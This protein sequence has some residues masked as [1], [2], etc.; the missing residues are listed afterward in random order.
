MTT[1]RRNQSIMLRLCAVLLVLAACTDDGEPVSETNTQEEIDEEVTEPALVDGRLRLL[2]TSW[3]FDESFSVGS[4]FEPSTLVFFGQ[5]N[6]LRFEVEALCG[7]GVGTITETANGLT[8]DEG[9]WTDLQR[10]E[11]LSSFFT[12][13]F[14]AELDDDGRLLV[15]HPRTN[16]PDQV[17]VF[18]H[19]QSTSINSDELDDRTPAD[20]FAASL[21]QSRWTVAATTGAATVTNEE[22]G[23]RDHW[24]AFGRDNRGEVTLTVVLGCASDRRVIEWTNNGFALTSRRGDIAT[25][26]MEGPPCEDDGAGVLE[27]GLAR[28]GDVAVSLLA[29]T[30]RLSG[31]FDEQEW[32]MTLEPWSPPTDHFTPLVCSEYQ[33]GET[34]RGVTTFTEVLPDGTSSSVTL[35]GFTVE[36]VDTLVVDLDGD[37]ESDRVVHATLR[38]LS[39]DEP[40]VD[41]IATCGLKFDFPSAMVRIHP[42]TVIEMGRSARDGMFSV[43]WNDN[44]FLHRTEF[45]VDGGELVA[46]PQSQTA[47]DSPEIQERLVVTS[48]PL[49]ADASGELASGVLHLRSWGCIE[50]RGANSA[51]L[52]FPAGRATWDPINNAVIVDGVSYV[53][54]DRIQV[55]R[56]PRP[57]FLEYFNPMEREQ[58]GINNHVVVSMRE[59][60]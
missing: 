33:V 3:V 60:G 42:H 10:C 21:R 25:S 57:E 50:L 54:G 32:S 31:E 38:G 12:G 2:G 35:D 24:V 39:V 16:Q 30:V 43:S 7:R 28:L 34:E 23:D 56:L 40:V 51:G 26:L 9:T 59:I 11:E 1:T 27:I 37:R 18:S 15:R 55:T 41:V 8:V 5:D 14:F 45:S 47:L 49:S 29:D 4:A 19:V 6:E 20:I 46:D 13:R 48:K 52:V 36:F 22:Q 53:D 44:D 58:C 17:L